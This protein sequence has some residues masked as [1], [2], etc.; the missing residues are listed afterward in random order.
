M[1]MVVMMVMMM[2][3]LSNGCEFLRLLQKSFDENTSSMVSVK[4][5]SEENVSLTNKLICN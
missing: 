2:M 3:I 1:M 5:L 4:I